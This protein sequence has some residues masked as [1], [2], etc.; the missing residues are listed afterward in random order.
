MK[1]IYLKIGLIVLSFL[2]MFHQT[3]I[4]LVVD[5]SND[6]NFSHGFLIPFIAGYLIWHKRDQL[7]G[8]DFQPGK[9]GLLIMRP[10]SGHIRT[11]RAAGRK[12]RRV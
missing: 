11:R 1:T 7:L 2:A 6:P 9:L 10:A 3:I 8:Q 5:W 4:K 12:S